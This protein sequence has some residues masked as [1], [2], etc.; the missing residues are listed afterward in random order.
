MPSAGDRRLFAGVAVAVVVADLA[1]KLLAQAWLAT[2]PGV[3]AVGDW[4][5]LRLVFNPGAA[6]GVS[7]GSWSR[8]GF[9]VIAIAAIVLLARLA[10]RADAG[11]W[12]RR[13][14]CGLVAGGAA[15]NLID[16]IRSSQGVV[17]FLDVG[18]GPHRWPTFNV[19]DIGVTVGALVLAWSL[20]NEDHRAELAD[21]VVT[22]EQGAIR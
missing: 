12:L 10:W 18:I 9:S 13:L 3:A 17:D 20:W 8:V 19:A 4:V 16:R 1:T 22:P 7:V 6:F 11:D 5:Q 15:G 21:A 14:A 2:S